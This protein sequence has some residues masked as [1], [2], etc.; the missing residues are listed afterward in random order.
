MAFEAIRY[1]SLFSMYGGSSA[2]VASMFLMTPETIPPYSEGKGMV[3]PPP[4]VPIGPNAPEMKVPV[5]G[6]LLV[7]LPYLSS[8]SQA[9]TDSKSCSMEPSLVSLAVFVCDSCFSRT[10]GLGQQ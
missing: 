9:T 3:A 5:P 7:F 6:N 10:L 4:Q 8:K 1:A 2:V